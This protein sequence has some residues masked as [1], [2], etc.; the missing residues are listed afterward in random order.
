[1]L[2]VVVHIPVTIPVTALSS[3]AAA[4]N[5]YG[6]ELCLNVASKRQFFV[7]L[8]NFF[9]SAWQIGIIF[10]RPAAPR[11]AGLEISEDIDTATPREPASPDGDRAGLGPEPE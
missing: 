9:E 5:Q 8:G 10:A 1:V 3:V 7:T 11:P 4:L 6:N 2:I